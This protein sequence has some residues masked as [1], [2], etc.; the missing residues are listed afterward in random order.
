MVSIIIPNYNHAPY[1]EQRIASV[2][3]QTWQDFEI[4]LLD[5][6][7]T[8][9]SRSIIEKYSTHRKVSNIVYNAVNSGNTFRQWAKGI[10]LSKGEYIWIAESDDWCE[11]S[12]LENI[13]GGMLE[14]DN[15]VLGY[16]QSCCVQDHNTILWQSFHGKLKDCIAGNE[17][18]SMYM[19]GNNTVYNASMAVW[20]KNA[21]G[22][23][24]D[25]FLQFKLCGD[26]LFWIELCRHGNVFVSGK[27]LN[28]FRK[29][30]H[31]TSGKAIAVGNNF[32]E[33]LQMFT[34]LYKRGLIGFEGLVVSLRREYVQYKAVA[35][36]LALE[37]RAQIK[38]LFFKEPGVKARI[39]NFYRGYYAKYIAREVL[40]RLTDRV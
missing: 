14:N 18:I 17:F 35:K 25:S 38:D 39:L 34:L 40:K 9:E 15:C 31:N 2:L 37:K 24:S 7:S 8:D 19:L 22:F 5:D 28:Y 11:P 6:C 23:V 27:V 10:A 30:Q 33:E 4:I 21:F 12:F 20:K 36:S 32:I 13:L 1:L 26:W 16:C 29:H 3:N